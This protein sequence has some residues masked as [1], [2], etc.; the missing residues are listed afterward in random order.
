MK[1]IYLVTLDSNTGTDRL[2]VD[3]N[4]KLVELNYDSNI[5]NPSDLI[6]DRPLLNF[7]K[8][9]FG[10]YIGW[11][12]ISYVIV[13][14]H[15]L[16]LLIKNRSNTYIVVTF[17]YPFWTPLMYLMKMTQRVK[18]MYQIPDMMWR[19]QYV[20]NYRWKLLSIISRIGIINAD[21]IL[22]P[23]ASAQ[24]DCITFINKRHHKKIA[25]L[26]APLNKEYWEKISP[27]NITS[28]QGK[29]FIFH[30]AG[31]KITKNT[32]SAIEAFMNIC[33]DDIYFVYI[34]N[35]SNSNK[36]DYDKIGQRVLALYNLS[37]GEMKW[38]YKNSLFVSIVS[39]EEGI[40]LPVLEAKFFGK[41]VV[42]S[43]ASALPEAAAHNA[44]FVDPFSTQS[45][46]EGY[47]KAMQKINYETCNNNIKFESKEYG[48]NQDEEIR[49][50]F[51]ESKI[52]KY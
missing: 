17:I 43:N 20:S 6:K 19:K 34:K 51:G 46:C 15:I 48:L 10:K 23:T 38:L 1:K 4:Q 28:L 16:S 30:P 36:A 8:K 13:E 31:L 9:K 26:T 42:V 2:I 40:G 39:I 21:L 7:I 25:R 29:K 5:L 50:V 44:I 33:M 52:I 27:L 14:L 18:Y 3:L 12:Y 45:I 47:K 24:I 49:L 35:S 41:T 32:I 22:T 11:R 37:D